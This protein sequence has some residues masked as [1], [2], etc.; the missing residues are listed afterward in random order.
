ML[1][2]NVLANET[3][4]VERTRQG[5]QEAFGQ[6]VQAYQDRLYSS[7]MHMVTCRA[8]AEDVVQEAFVQAYTRLD[9]FQ[10]KSTFYTWLYRITI[11]LALTWGRRRKTRMSLESTQDVLLEE[12]EDTGERPGERMARQEDASLIKR[13]LNALGEEHRTIL[14]MRGVQGF[15]YATIAQILGLNPGTVRSRLHRARIQ[16]RQHLE[17][18]Q[19]CY[20]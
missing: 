2:A 3:E 8:D 19:Y 14:V 15:D 20:A 16:L 1:K 17:R 11:N 7:V 13:A 12:P 10:G 9:S 5:D 18:M 4:L 6:L